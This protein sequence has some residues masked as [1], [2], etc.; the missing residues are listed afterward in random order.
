VFD[1]FA[2]L[3]KTYKACHG[4]VDAPKQQGNP[5]HHRKEGHFRK[6]EGFQWDDDDI[7]K[8]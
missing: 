3:D 2:L 5:I 8:N 4:H 7:V 1:Y 6:I